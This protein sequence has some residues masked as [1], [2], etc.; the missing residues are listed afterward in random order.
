MA[1]AIQ[2]FSS[3]PAANNMTIWA[4]SKHIEAGYADYAAMVGK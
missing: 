2:D 1:L 3:V 4:M